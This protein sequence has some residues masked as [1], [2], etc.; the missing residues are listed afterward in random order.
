M[1]QCVKGTKDLL[2]DSISAWQFVENVFKTVSSRYGYEE[3][4]TPIFEKT[5]VF[6]RSIGEATDIVN[7]EMYTFEDRGG[8]SITLRPEMTAALVRSVIQH[9]LMNSS[10]TQRLW[11][12]GPFFRYERPQKGRLR[13]FHQFGAECLGSPNPESDAEIILLASDIIRSAGI[14]E[15]KLLI[16]SLGNTAVRAAYREELVGF[17]RSK[18]NELTEESRNRMDINP[19]RALDSKAPQDIAALE[20]APV[21]TDFLDSESRDHFD[22]VKGLIRN[23]G[24]EIVVQPRLVRGLDY[25][26]HTVFEFQSSALGAQDSLGG[27]GRYNTLF[28]QLGGKETPAVG[29]ALGVERLLLILENLGRSFGKSVSTDIFVAYASTAEFDEAFNLCNQL[30]QKGHSVT[31]DLLRRSL[32]S[33]F[34]EANRIGARY[35]LVIGEE[36]MKNRTVQVK[37]MTRSEQS[38]RSMETILDFEFD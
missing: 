5:E 37:N 14:G 19:L 15:I 26:S 6:S 12:F 29:F 8:D 31:I 21:I 22:A 20:N 28:T 2:P 1:I 27:G 34:K 4:R 35:T 25:Y 18:Q 11:Y 23:C 10:P 7:K 38:E 16:N 13:Q 24:A 32:K 9:S 36:E 3:M 17:L 33:Q 30:R